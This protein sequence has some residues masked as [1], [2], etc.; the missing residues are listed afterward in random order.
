MKTY[1]KILL[2]ALFS[3]IVL[4]LASCGRKEPKQHGQQIGNRDFTQVNSILKEPGNFDGKTV[5]IQGNII[6]ECPTGCWFEVKDEA[7]VIYVDLKPSGFAIPQKTG[8]TVTVEGKVKVRD[9]QPIIIGT[10]VEIK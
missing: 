1:Y 10:G 7:G 4:A 8:K 9:N 6:R 5:T 2:I 3:G